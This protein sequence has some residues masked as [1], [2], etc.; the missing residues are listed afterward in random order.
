MKTFYGFLRCDTCI[1]NLNQKNLLI[2]DLS[3]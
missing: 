3:L 2:I 1:N